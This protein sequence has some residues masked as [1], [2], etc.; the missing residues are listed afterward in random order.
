VKDI[1]AFFEK[2]RLQDYY[3][4]QDLNSDSPVIPFDPGIHQKLS[5]GVL[6]GYRNYD[7]FYERYLSAVTVLAVQNLIR[8]D[9]K[10]LDIG[11]GDGF[12]KFFFDWKFPFHLNWH[13]I[14][15]WKERIAF[16]RHIGYQ[17]DEVDLEKGKLP[18]ADSS[19]DL[20]IA[21][22]VIEHIPNPKA[23]VA[24]MGRVLKPGGIFIIATPTK[25]PGVAQ[26]DSWYHHVSRRHRGDTQQAFTHRKLERL[27]LAALRQDKS[28]II[29]KRGFRLISGRKRLPLENWKWFYRFNTWLAKR[30]L[31][32]V[33]EINIILKK[34]QDL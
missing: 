12:F 2:Y 26:L 23:M 15:V 32:L 11:S 1:T 33:P 21:S 27:T 13:G 22:H 3:T 25:L 18:Y 4:W 5:H 28:T 9:M 17:I 10:I 7:L 30:W 20:V 29:D 34:N 14:E 31:L 8:E 16:C 24:E 6:P 19:F